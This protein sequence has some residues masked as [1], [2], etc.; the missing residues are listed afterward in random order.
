MSTL[1]IEKNT[2]S[3]GL[4]LL[5]SQLTTGETADWRSWYQAA[6]EQLEIDDSL[7]P[8][9]TDRLMDALLDA[10][11]ALQE[12]R[13][14]EPSLQRVVDL[15]TQGRQGSRLQSSWLRRAEALA[16]EDLETET[17]IDLQEAL[18]LLQQ[19]DVESTESWLEETTANL[20]A[21]WHEY[22]NLSILDE[23]ITCETVLGHRFLRDG[24]EFWLEALDLLKEGLTE[25]FDSQTILDRARQGQRRLVLLQIIEEENA[26]ARER[27]FANWN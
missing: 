4:D 2:T 1:L 7:D 24:V 16:N 25:N 8:Q 5:I 23:E 27:Y 19:G 12:G 17:W 9:T 14:E 22:E 10:E 13:S 21:V 6:L 26:L 20:I 18:E 15:Y 3:R 11:T